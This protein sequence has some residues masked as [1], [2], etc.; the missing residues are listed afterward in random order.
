[1]MGCLQDGLGNTQHI[2]EPSADG[3]VQR[4]RAVGLE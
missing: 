1:M 2:A 3:T 4:A